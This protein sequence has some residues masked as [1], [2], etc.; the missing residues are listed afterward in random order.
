M[1]S[2]GIRLNNPGNIEKGL[3][4][5]GLADVQNDSRFCT[6]TTPEYGIRAICKILGNYQTKHKISTIRGIINRWA[7]PS[8]NKTDKYAE[9]V[10]EWSGFGIEDIL[11]L[12]DRGTLL[13][14]TKAISQQ[15]CGVVPWSDEVYS[16]G[17]NLAIG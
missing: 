10:S 4:W 14:L 6:F 8:E 12:K 9:N 2:K 5:S 16:K 3:N 11:D 15:E 1:P 7:P 17:V 13:E